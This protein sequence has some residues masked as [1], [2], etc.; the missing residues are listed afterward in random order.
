M[1]ADEASGLGLRGASGNTPDEIQRELA[2]SQDCN[3]GQVFSSKP[4]TMPGNAGLSLYQC[5]DKGKIDTNFYCN[6]EVQTL[7]DGSTTTRTCDDCAGYGVPYGV[8]WICTGCTGNVGPCA[9]DQECC[10]GKC[11]KWFFGWR[12]SCKA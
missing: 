1:A 4:S 11:D 9:S 2:S 8:N 12:G 7:S 6:Y 10:S 5:F 3:P